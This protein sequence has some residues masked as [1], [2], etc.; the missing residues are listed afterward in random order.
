MRP[1]PVELTSEVRE[2]LEKRVAAAKTARRDWQRAWIVLLAAGGAADPEIV[3]EVGLS[4]DRVREWRHRFLEQ[5]LAG[6]KD[7]PRSGRPLVYGPYERLM[8]VKTITTR[9]PEAG[10]LT[11]RRRK[12]R[13]SVPE[14]GQ[15]MRETL[16]IPISDSQVFRICVSLDLKPWQTQSWMTSH[17]PNFDA[18]AADVCGLYLDPPANAV[19]F[20]ID[21]KTG[22]Q[23]KS[24]KNPTRAALPAPPVMKELLAANP[25]QLVTTAA[26]VD[27]DLPATSDA[28]V[29]TIRPTSGNAEPAVTEETVTPG[30]QP[31]AKNPPKP[32]RSRQEF[33]YVRNGTAALYAAF[34]VGDGSVEGWVTDST[35]STNFVSFLANIE[36][37]V[38]AHLEIHCVIDN[39]SAHGTPAVEEFLEAHPRVFLHRTPTHA[40]WLNQV[41]CWF[42]ILTRQLLATAEFASPAD[43]ANAIIDYI[44]DYNQRAKPFKWT[45]DAKNAQA[46]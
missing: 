3:A 27:S 41:E 11:D 32:K 30:R 39:L 2:V 23:A 31:A 38:P 37:N 46:A 15:Q 40:S 26:S 10:Q 35:R 6:L 12:A 28:A 1:R 16:G 29:N 8:L 17:D 34:N 45:Y 44:D 9:P 43:L 7:R 4:R 14:V 22:I 33:E 13:M 21:E 24:R 19:V 20:S 42:S 25:A 5:G 36:A 18:K